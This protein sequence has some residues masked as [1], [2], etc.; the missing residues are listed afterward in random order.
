[1]CGCEGVRVHVCEIVSVRVWGLD[2]VILHMV[3]CDGLQL[4][5]GWG[6]ED[7]GAGGGREGGG[8]LMSG[9]A[10]VY[11]HCSCLL[12]TSL[13]A[14]VGK[15]TDNTATTYWSKQ[16]AAHTIRGPV[17]AQNM[18]CGM[19]C[20]IFIGVSYFAALIICGDTN[21]SST[22]FIICGMQ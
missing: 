2:L 4:G 8:P 15:H 14:S 17:F 12:W 16:F 3:G 11:V 5:S 10:S 21:F 22:Q 1:M 9:V 18:I 6:L 13:D 7:S 19:L 20:N